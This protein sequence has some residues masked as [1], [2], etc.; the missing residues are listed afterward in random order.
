MHI[1][2][3]AG[4]LFF[5]ISL[6]KIREWP[7]NEGNKVIDIWFSEEFNSYPFKIRVKTPIGEIEANYSH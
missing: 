1:Y 5:Q 4:T 3:I 2:T 6:V 7:F